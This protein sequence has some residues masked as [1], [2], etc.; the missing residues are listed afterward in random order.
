M[1]IL[2]YTQKNPLNISNLNFFFQP[3]S[4]MYTVG[5]F[6]TRK[7]DLHI[8][9]T[10]T[11]VDEGISDTWRR[12][13]VIFF[14][15]VIFSLTRYCCYSTWG[16]CWEEN[17]WFSCDRWRLETGNF[18]YFKFSVCIWTLFLVSSFCCGKNFSLLLI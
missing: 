6:M 4:G 8:V 14:F 9:K 18:I 10:T 17:N 11:T 12:T 3:R 1:F 5:D 15:L 16:S 13:L 7:E 2:L